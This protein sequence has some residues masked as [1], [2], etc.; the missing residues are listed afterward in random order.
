MSIDAE[1]YR[2][3]SA[4]FAAPLVLIHGLW[5]G[6]WMWRQFSQYLSHRG[7]TSYALSWRA[8]ARASL[9]SSVLAALDDFVRPLD[10]PPIVI[11]HD[12]G[13]HLALHL[14]GTQAAVALPPP[15]A[16]P[17]APPPPS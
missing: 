11:G 17:A 7:W 4:K 3:E 14:A 10:V 5:S 16:G 8:T 12:L 13:A 1:V 2:A 15:A 9:W 6:P